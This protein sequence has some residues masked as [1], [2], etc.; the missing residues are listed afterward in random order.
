[1]DKYI[2]K[3]RELKRENI[4]LKKYKVFVE[5]N[6]DTKSIYNDIENY[7]KE[8]KKNKILVSDLKQFIIK[9]KELLIKINNLKNS[10][11]SF[12]NKSNFYKQQIEINILN[13]KIKNN[14]KEKVEI[15]KQNENMYKRNKFLEDILLQFKQFYD[16][17]PGLGAENIMKL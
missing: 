17:I 3:I 10:E 14:E 11:L 5:K 9:N 6:K 16:S 1:M 13:E 8:I 15:N 4:K 2:K 12:V 7:Q